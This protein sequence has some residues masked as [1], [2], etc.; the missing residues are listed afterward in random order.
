METSHSSLP[1]LSVQSWDV[2]RLCL[3]WDM[4]HSESQITRSGLK[5]S[6][7]R[8]RS[9]SSGP[10]PKCPVQGAL[11][12][13]VELLRLSV[14]LRCTSGLNLR[15]HSVQGK[16]EIRLCWNP[17]FFYQCTQKSGLWKM[18]PLSVWGRWRCIF[19]D[20]G[21]H[22]VPPTG[23]WPMP[24]LSVVNSA[25][26]SPSP[27]QMEQKEVIN[28]GKPDFTAQGLSPSCGNALWLPWVILTVPMATWPL[29]SA[30]V[31]QGKATIL[32]M[33]LEWNFPR[34]ENKRKQASKGRY[35]VVKLLN[36]GFNCS[37]LKNPILRDKRGVKLK[38]AL[39]SKPAGL[40]R[41]MTNVPK[42]QLSLADQGQEFLNGNFRSAQVEVGD[43]LPAE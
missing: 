3:S 33:L 40:G 23:V 27:P 11:V 43:R 25:V 15:V 24:M 19:L 22:S 14:Q 32:R 4:C 6:G 37:L 17:V 7:V 20:N 41:Q 30:Q 36:S 38:I 16:K 26:E 31:R 12:T 5:R 10:A 8:G 2:V 42:N 28:S 9:L 21:E 29:W 18:T 34:A 35:Y 39:L 1:R 13:T